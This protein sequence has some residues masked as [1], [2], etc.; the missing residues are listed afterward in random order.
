MTSE[1]AVD[2]AMVTF[3]IRLEQHGRT[4]DRAL[5]DRLSREI[6]ARGLG[7]QLS[8]AIARVRQLR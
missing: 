5:A 8:A 4:A 1:D 2:I 3:Q 7:E 6:V